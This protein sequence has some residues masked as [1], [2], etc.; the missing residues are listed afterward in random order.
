MVGLLCVK[1]DSL[2]EQ[3]NSK[4]VGNKFVQVNIIYLFIMIN[5]GAH[6]GGVLCYVLYGFL[7]HLLCAI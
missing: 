1:S 2:K 3:F 5:V 7:D 4:P 6:I